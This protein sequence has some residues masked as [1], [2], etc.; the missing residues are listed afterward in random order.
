M[1]AHC[2]TVLMC[3]HTYV[4]HALSPMAR[5]MDN[6]LA[7]K[8]VADALQ[9]ANLTSV[10][11]TM[12]PSL[13][14]R[15]WKV[16]ALEQSVAVAVALIASTQL[17]LLEIVSVEVLITYSIPERHGHIFYH[18]R[19]TTAKFMSDSRAICMATVTTYQQVLF[20]TAV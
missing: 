18:Q 19:V 11:P 3:H 17:L 13:L 14:Q 16:M 20:F 2:I 4:Q 10:P 12:V 6:L 8:S 7:S 5:L 9:L 1:S 15:P